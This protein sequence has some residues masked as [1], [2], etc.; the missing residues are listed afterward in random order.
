M[1]INT[2]KKN[3]N[4]VS[5]APNSIIHSMGVERPEVLLP[6]TPAGFSV[7]GPGF[8]LRHGSGGRQGGSAIIG[9]AVQDRLQQRL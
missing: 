8:H 9:A 2:C 3:Q 5:R 7:Q 1:H 4:Y 6:P